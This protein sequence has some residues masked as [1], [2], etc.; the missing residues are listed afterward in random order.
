MRGTPAALPLTVKPRIHSILE[1]E[2]KKDKIS[3]SFKKRLLIILASIEGKSK[4]S[5]AEDLGVTKVM[6]NQWRKRWSQSEPK[7]EQ[8]IQN[9]YSSRPLKDH[10]ILKM[11][12][13]IL[14]DKP[15]SGTPKRIILEAEE[16]IVALAC[17]KPE[18][19]GIQMSQWTHEMLAHV[20]KAEAF[21]DQ[22][23][24]RHI[25]NILKKKVKP[26]QD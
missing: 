2:S 23:S 16:L 20:A 15:R 24:P 25:G 9:G 8:A 19:H 5:I 21:V 22:I 6:I 17:D 3:V 13:E 10:E 26:A 14:R 12:G 18:N 7:I 11:I 1:R 4:Y